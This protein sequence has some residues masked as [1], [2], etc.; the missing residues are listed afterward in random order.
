MFVQLDQ[1]PQV[2]RRRG[3]TCGSHGRSP[4]TLICWADLQKTHESEILNVNTG[5]LRSSPQWRP[6]V[7][8]SLTPPS[9]VLRARLR[10]H[11]EVRT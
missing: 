1:R 6:S 9:K 11:P 10:I 7:E 3:A 4:A 2:K 5:T 8:S